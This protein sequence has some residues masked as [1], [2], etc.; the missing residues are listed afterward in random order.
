MEIA[1]VIVTYNPE[2][3]V[4]NDLVLMLIKQVDKVII[5]D[6]NSTNKYNINYINENVIVIKQDNN[7]GLAKAQNI[8]INTVINSCTHILIFDQDSSI[9]E[10]F[11]KKQLECET[12]LLKQNVKLSAVGPAFIDEDT[13]YEY[14]VT[15]YKGPFIKHVDIGDKPVKATFIIAS[16]SLI[17]T[18]VLKDVGLMLDDFFIDFVDVEWCLRANSKGY[19]CFINPYVKMSHCIG[20][21]RIKIGGRMISMH[22]DFRKFYIYR[23]GMYMLRLS[24]VPLGYKVRVFIFNIIRS[25]LGVCIS[26]DR[27]ATL[28]ATFNGWSKGFSS[29]K[30]TP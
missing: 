19:S 29:F 30:K 17:R 2:V 9:S 6:N 5:V 10:N 25:I 3:N 26:P 1:A 22:S 11:V 27:K 15:V 23:N 24:Y 13:Q 21:L 28:K 20:E 4:L 16:G 12:E 8:G 18:V 7:I 14:P